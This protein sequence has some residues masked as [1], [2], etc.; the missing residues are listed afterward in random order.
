MKNIKLMVVCIY[1]VCLLMTGCS[2]GSEEAKAQ[3]PDEEAPEISRAEVPDDGN[4]VF[5]YFDENLDGESVPPNSAFTVSVGSSIR[6]TVSSVSVSGN[7]VLVRFTG[8]RI[9][10]GEAVTVTY[11]KP[12]SNPLMDTSGNELESFGGSAVE[13]ENNSEQTSVSV[14]AS[15]RTGEGATHSCTVRINGQLVRLSVNGL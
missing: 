5:L 9:R 13:V 14:G 6:F 4:R 1:G 7:F 11:T 15:P 2:G 8:G 3:T 10:E 12:T